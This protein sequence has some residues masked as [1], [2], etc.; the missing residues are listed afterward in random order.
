MI[1][2]TKVYRWLHRR[3]RGRRRRGRDRDRGRWLLNV[4]HNNK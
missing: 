2:K 4:K 1:T 3:R